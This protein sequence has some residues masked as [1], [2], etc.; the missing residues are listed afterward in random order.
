[1]NKAPQVAANIGANFY[2]TGLG[3]LVIDTRHDY[4]DGL[5]MFICCDTL[6]KQYYLAIHVH[7]EFK[8]WL[9]APMS[10]DTVHHLYNTKMDLL[11]VFKKPLNSKVGLVHVFPLERAELLSW[12][13]T[14]S[15]SPEWLPES[16][17]T[18]F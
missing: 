1:M 8:L 2:V 18:L 3:E 5:K 17:E 4:Y 9:F 13:P 6:R 7:D 14:E 15:I 11:S 10:K 16:G 12:I